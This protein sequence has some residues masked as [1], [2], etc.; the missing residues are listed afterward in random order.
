MAML[1]EQQRVTV[2]DQV[3]IVRV[4]PKSL[5][6]QV[7]DFADQIKAKLP[8]MKVLVIACDDVKVLPRVDKQRLL[9]E[10]GLD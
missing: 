7:K 4:D 3:V 2:D 5:P 6:D 10:L 9:A 8:D 1:T